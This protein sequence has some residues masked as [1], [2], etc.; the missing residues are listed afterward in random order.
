MPV[1]A[2]IHKPPLLTPEKPHNLWTVRYSLEAC[3]EHTI[4][5]HGRSI[6]KCLQYNVVKV[7][8]ILDVGN[9]VNFAM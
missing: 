4:G 1:S 3:I 6:D 2:E 8:F 5:N 7:D 9:K